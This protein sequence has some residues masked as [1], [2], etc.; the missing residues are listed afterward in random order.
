MPRP[1]SPF[2]EHLLDL[3]SGFGEV[4][5]RR[6]FGGY[7]I[8]R[9]GLMFGLV[10]DDELYLKVDELTKPTFDEAGLEPFRF[11]MKNGKVGVM[12]Y[13]HV[14]ESALNSPM[15][16]KKWALLGWDAAQR[17]AASKTKSKRRR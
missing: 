10:A 1:P 14:P 17:N 3:L 12:S 5:A 6:M 15:A 2:V 7:G 13:H 9:D 8:Y 16:M 4:S 11:E